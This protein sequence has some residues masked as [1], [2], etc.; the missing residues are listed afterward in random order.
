VS[1]SPSVIRARGYRAEAQRLREQA[2]QNPWSD[3]REQLERIARQYE[4][5]AETIERKLGDD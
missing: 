2:A 1:D 3:H 4:L 5:M